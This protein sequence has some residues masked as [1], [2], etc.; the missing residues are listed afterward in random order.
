MFWEQTKN[1]SVSRS[2]LRE[3]EALWGV[4]LSHVM[5]QYWS[6]SCYEPVLV[7]HM[8]WTSIGLS[9]VMNQYW[10][11]SCYE[12]VLV[13][14]MLWN[15]IGLSHVMNQYWPVTWMKQDGNDEWIMLNHANITCLCIVIYK[16]TAGTAQAE[17]LIDMCTI[18]HWVGWN[19]SS[20]LTIN[21]GSFKIDFECPCLRFFS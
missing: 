1:I 10:S 6:V 7:C 4:G 5:N 15:S 11:V 14:H 12:T 2:Q 8:L 3:K 13:C 21:N 9:H 18:V 17:L 19:L 16:T 20:A